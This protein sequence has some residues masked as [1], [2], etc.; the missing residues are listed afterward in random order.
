MKRKSKNELNAVLPVF[1]KKY[2][3]V[4]FYHIGAFCLPSILH[5]AGQT[6]AGLYLFWGFLGLVIL[7]VLC[8]LPR[9]IRAVRLK[10]SK[11]YQGRCYVAWSVHATSVLIGAVFAKTVGL[12]QANVPADPLAT[13]IQ[14][15]SPFPQH[16]TIANRSFLEFSFF[17]PLLVFYVVRRVYEFLRFRDRRGSL[18]NIKLDVLVYGLGF[19]VG[20]TCCGYL[21]FSDMQCTAYTKSSWLKFFVPF[22][23]VYTVCLIIS[24]ILLRKAY[25]SGKDLLSRAA[26]LPQ[27][28]IDGKPYILSLPTGGRKKQRR[29]P[30]D[31]DTVVSIHDVNA[32]ADTEDGGICDALHCRSTVSWCRDILPGIPP[33]HPTRAGDYYWSATSPLCRKFNTGYRP[34]LRPLNPETMDPDPSLL[35]DIPDGTVLALGSLYMDE[36][37]L[38]FPC[39]PELTKEDRQAA[40]AQVRRVSEKKYIELLWQNVDVPDYTPGAQ[41]RIGDS[42]PSKEIQWIKCGDFLIADRNLLK[43]ISW[44][45]LDRNGLIFSE[46]GKQECSK[47]E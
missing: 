27:V 40:R 4:V 8:H 38:P 45:D 46:R 36:T 10:D 32:S 39:H 24:L 17:I 16:W 25:I 23:L 3:S 5:L 13:A 2:R 30:N 14:S 47:Q 34:I 41:L 44:N 33:F 6:R 43:N 12:L 37:P 7:D 1:W 19:V 11:P 31:W 18:F 15:L 21:A 9:F 28:T 35:S 29:E 20:S 22:L 42:V 26:S